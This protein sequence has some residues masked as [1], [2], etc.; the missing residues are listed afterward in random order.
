MRVR[1]TRDSVAFGC[2]VFKTGFVSWEVTVPETQAGSTG[3]TKTAS[4]P[5]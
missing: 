1:I 2:A 3:F 5:D 4:R